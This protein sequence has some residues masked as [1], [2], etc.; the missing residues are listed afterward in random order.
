LI[1]DLI[2]AYGLWILFI[3]I[4]LESLGVP[5]PGETVLVSAAL[6]AGSTNQLAIAS[7]VIVAAAAA[8]VGGMVGYLIGRLI[9]IP[10]LV[11]YGRY[12]RLDEPRLKIGQYL[13]LRHGGKIVFF[14][15]FVALLRTFA[16]LLAGANRMGLPYFLVMN[17]LG[18][19]L[20]AVL[21]GGGAYFIGE[22]ITR[23]TGPVSLVLLIMA[24]AAVAAGIIY[25]RRHE[26][27]LAQRAESAIPGAL[28]GVPASAQDVDDGGSRRRMT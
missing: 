21:F 20:W 14:G 1:H 5:L 13:F 17:A 7:V 8:T 10:L 11:R 15:R 9:G 25:L 16:G 19:T 24:I 18:G 6:Y 3:G 23:V 28:F 2:Q 27:E 22:Q 26:K 4:M 12:V